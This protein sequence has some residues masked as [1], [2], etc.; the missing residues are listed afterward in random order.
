MKN[1]RASPLMC[2]QN[3]QIYQH[4]VNKKKCVYEFSTDSN[5]CTYV[6]IVTDAVFLCSCPNAICNAAT[7]KNKRSVE[8]YRT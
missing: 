4:D 5:G 2:R 1:S 6:Y 7:I 8:Q 3:I